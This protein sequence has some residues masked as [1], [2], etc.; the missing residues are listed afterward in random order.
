MVHVYMLEPMIKPN[1]RIPIIF[2]DYSNATFSDRIL[3]S[4]W[5]TIMGA[6]S[7]LDIKLFMF[8]SDGENRIRKFVHEALYMKPTTDIKHR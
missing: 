4:N 7:D 2:H 5:D 8:S 3:K 6:C 1:Y